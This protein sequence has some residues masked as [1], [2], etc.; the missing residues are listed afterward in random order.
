MKKPRDHKLSVKLGDLL[1]LQVPLDSIRA[2]LSE[3]EPLIEQNKEALTASVCFLEATD[4]EGKKWLVRIIKVG[5]SLNGKIY[6]AE[7]CREAVKAGLFENLPCLG[8]PKVGDDGRLIHDHPT[9]G[10]DG[11]QMVRNTIGKFRNAR[12]DEAAQEVVSEFHFIDSDMQKKNL[13]A[14]KVDGKPLFGFSINGSGDGEEMPDGRFRVTMI[15]SMNSTD[16]VTHPAAGGS[17]L[18][19]LAASFKRESG[20]GEMSKMDKVHQHILLQLCRD[21]KP[22]FL[23]G[24]DPVKLVEMEDEAMALVKSLIALDNP[25]VQEHAEVLQAILSALEEEYKKMMPDEPTMEMDDDAEKKKKYM[26]EEA[27]EESTETADDID[28][29][30]QKAID[31][32]MFGKDAEAEFASAKLPE[33]IEEAVRKMVRKG[34]RKSLAEAIK[35]GKELAEAGGWEGPKVT[36][37]IK[38]VEEERDRY[39][40]ALKAAVENKSSI[41][42]VPAFRG[43]KEAMAYYTGIIDPEPEIRTAAV[44]TAMREAFHKVRSVVSIRRRASMYESSRARLTEG[45][46]SVH[47]LSMRESVDTGTF[48]SIFADTITRLLLDEINMPMLNDW[49]QVVSHFKSADD[50]R[51]VHFVRDGQYGTIPVVNEGDPFQPLPTP[52]DEEVSF[53]AVKRGGTEDQTWEA[54]LAD[55]IGALARTPAKLM[56]AMLQTRRKEV[57]ALVHDNTVNIYD[58]TALYTAGH[59]NTSAVALSV[60]ELSAQRARMRQR[61][62]FNGANFETGLVQKFLVVPSELEEAANRFTRSS[63]LPVVEFNSGVSNLHNGIQVIV[64]DHLPET[65]HWFGI[66]DPSQIPTIGFVNIKGFEQ[67]RITVN[68]D[69]TVGPR[70]DEDKVTMKIKDAYE[71]EILDFRAFQGNLV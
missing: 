10:E 49:R 1:N 19:R 42:G 26:A 24:R 45:L 18:R 46:R 71:A 9:E 27:V 43:L 11:N 31:A 21:L 16:A 48:T 15:S 70:F 52:S 3:S 60:D 29:R 50:F 51:D 65:D 22:A 14:F 62:A 56:R 30:I 44:G 5:E 59:G 64:L 67:P 63:G 36:G 2:T 57:W 61:T 37:T 33:K 68:D 40:K 32:R 8:L 35:T 13:E 54:L 23:E 34:D 17:F 7:A 47:G 38:V 53:N 4:T 66:A 6:T 58:G 20:G 39:A 12:F 55:D 41:D 69:E 28:A 25:A